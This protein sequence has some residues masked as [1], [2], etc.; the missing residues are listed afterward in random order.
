MRVYAIGDIHGQFKLLQKAHA[1]IEQDKRR[2]ADPDALIVHVGDLVD[3]GP[4]SAGVVRFLREG[5][6]G[7]APWVVLKGNH[8][9]MFARFVTDPDWEDPA[10]RT[11]LTWLHELIGGEATLASYGVPGSAVADL[12]DAQSAA[13]DYVDPRDAAFLDA[14]PL[15]FAKGTALFVH[16]GLRPGVPL[17]A[18]IEQDLLWI[19]DPFLLDPRDHGALVVHG[20]TAIHRPLHYRNR[21]NIDSRAAY[22]GPLA[23]VVIED[24]DVFLLSDAGR[25]PILPL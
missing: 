1:L 8:D 18:Q 25:V 19:R 12:R 15:H 2:C 7:G 13:K 22:G 24:R 9:R 21:L 5:L 10:L 23:A 16:A 6:D 17:D 4:D 11:G 14:L 3:R 20:H